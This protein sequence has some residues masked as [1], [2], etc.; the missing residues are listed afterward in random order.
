MCR[1]RSRCC[2]VAGSITSAT[3]TARH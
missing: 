2:W 3:Q 1:R